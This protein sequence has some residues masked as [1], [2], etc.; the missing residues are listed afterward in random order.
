MQCALL[1]FVHG[2][3]LPLLL[4]Q[5]RRSFAL[6]WRSFA[7]VCHQVVLLMFTDVLHYRC[8]ARCVPTLVSPPTYHHERITTKVSPRKY[9]HESIATNVGRS[10]RFCTLF[11]RIY[12]ALLQMYRASLQIHGTFRQMFGAFFWHGG[13]LLFHY[14]PPNLGC[15]CNIELHKV[16]HVSWWG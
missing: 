6:L 8:V 14:I 3:S 10:M 1:C 7:N 4:P 16:G 11:W 2:N 12:R 5:C 9:R 13:C 15:F